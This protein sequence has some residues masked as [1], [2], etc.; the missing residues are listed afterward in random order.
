MKAFLLL[1]FFALFM[2]RN[3]TSYDPR[4]LVKRYLVIS[5][6]TA[7]RIL[8]DQS[9]PQT[10]RG[11]NTEENK[12]KM[13]LLGLSFY[14]LCALTILIQVVLLLME[15]MGAFS[16]TLTL[17]TGNIRLHADSLNEAI[18][19]V[20]GLLLLVV[21]VTAYFINLLFL[22]IRKPEEPGRKLSIGISL[23]LLTMFV[24]FAAAGF[25]NLFYL[26]RQI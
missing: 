25:L 18:V 2:A 1:D 17:D 14:I 24:L 13:S 3:T 5:N 19:L 20:S 11:E 6:P 4:Q 22:T 10:G 12:N 16:Y 8:I 7:A 15:P 26:I 9:D 21:T 23:F